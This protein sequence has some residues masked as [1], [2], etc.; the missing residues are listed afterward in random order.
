LTSSSRPCFPAV[1]PPPPQLWRI[2]HIS[3]KSLDKIID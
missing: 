1:F 2:R 3:E